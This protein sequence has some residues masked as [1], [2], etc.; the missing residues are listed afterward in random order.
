[1]NG[2]GVKGTRNAAQNG[3]NGNGNGTA[4]TQPPCGDPVRTSF[5]LTGTVARNMAVVCAMEGITQSQYIEDLIKDDL[6]R[7]KL[8]PDTAPD[9]A[10][11]KR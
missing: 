3:K 5:V 8:N 9:W 7:R 4:A 2:V 6:I 1:M 10:L 11:L